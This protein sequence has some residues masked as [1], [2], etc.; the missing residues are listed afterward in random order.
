VAH[1]AGVGVGVAR[2]APGPGT[3]QQQQEQEQQDANAYRA[4]GAVKGASSRWCTEEWLRGNPH[5]QYCG[6]TES[7]WGNNA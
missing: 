6:C 7:G 4:K 1:G 2:Q 3:Q 5:V